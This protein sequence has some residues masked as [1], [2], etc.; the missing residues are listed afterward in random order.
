MPGWV[1]GRRVYWERNLDGDLE[2]YTAFYY[3]S[4]VSQLSHAYRWC[5][6][7]IGLRP[8]TV[9]GTSPNCPWTPLEHPEHLETQ[10]PRSAILSTPVQLHLP[11][12]P[13]YIA[14]L[15]TVIEIQMHG[16]L[17]ACGWEFVSHRPR[18]SQ[19]A[20]KEVGPRGPLISIKVGAA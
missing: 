1:G 18:G 8:L 3:K 13:F 14:L 16:L 15:S 4:L 20:L 10:S 11:D 9:S 5:C 2:M 19:S 6:A 12:P 17:M 7:Q